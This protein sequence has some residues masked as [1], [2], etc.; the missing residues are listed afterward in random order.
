M[1]IPTYLSDPEF[2]FNLFLEGYDCI[3]FV[4]GR[5]LCGIKRL[6]FTIGL[7]YNITP[8]PKAP[9]GRYCYQ[10]R[11]EAEADLKQ[12]DG[13]SDPQGDW[14]KHFGREVQY[15]NPKNPDPFDSYY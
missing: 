3:T 10:T 4:P 7:F 2:T 8:F 5:G 11:A 1:S 9:D 6:A 13:C 14:I 15:S 12:W